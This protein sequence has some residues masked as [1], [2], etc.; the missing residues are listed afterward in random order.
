LQQIWQRHPSIKL[1]G[2]CGLFN[3]Q[4]F[5]IKLLS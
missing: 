4:L 3:V 2:L 5:H 1:D